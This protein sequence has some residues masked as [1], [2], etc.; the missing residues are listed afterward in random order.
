M[1]L[2]VFPKF[3]KKLGKHGCCV[4]GP[5]ISGV[6]FL[7]IFSSQ[8]TLPEDDAS[9]ASTIFKGP[10]VY[11]FGMMLFSMGNSCT[12][13]SL[14][15]LISRYAS[16]LSQA[17]V[18]GKYQ[19]AQAAVGFL[20]PLVGGA[21]ID[22]SA[23]ES[24]PAITAAHFFLISALM[25]YVIKLNHDIHK[26]DPMGGENYP[27]HSWCE[28]VPNVKNPFTKLHHDTHKFIEPTHHV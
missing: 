8:R 25:R 26:L 16:S 15:S 1:N 22:S 6:G 23:W 3:L 10:V 11:L 27:D 13:S 19:S 7:I 17:G 12:Q 9:A 2:L 20:A 4:I 21:I 5:L 14:T 18:Q 24:S 28:L